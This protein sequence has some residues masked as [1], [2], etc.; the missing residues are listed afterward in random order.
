MG[1]CISISAAQPSVQAD[2]PLDVPHDQS[3]ACQDCFHK[4]DTTFKPESR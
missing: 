2:L 1:L 3:C 4:A